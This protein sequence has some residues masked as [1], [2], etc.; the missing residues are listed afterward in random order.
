MRLYRAETN[1]RPT[2]RTPQAYKAPM[3]AKRYQKLS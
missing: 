1:L 3:P 2:D